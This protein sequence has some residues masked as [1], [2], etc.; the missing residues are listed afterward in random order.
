MCL[1]VSWHSSLLFWVSLTLVGIH[2]N[3]E[4]VGMKSDVLGVWGE[5]NIIQ[6]RKEMTIFGGQVEGVTASLY[7]KL[8]G[9][10][11]RASLFQLLY[12]SASRCVLSVRRATCSSP[13]ILKL[14]DGSQMQFLWLS[15]AAEVLWQLS[16][17]DTWTRTGEFYFLGCQEGC[18]GCHGSWHPDFYCVKPFITTAYH[19][20]CFLT[21]FC[22]VSCLLL[23]LGNVFFLYV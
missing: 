21:M 22:Q 13:V 5:A 9:W 4:S 18:I 11:S 10:K 2:P 16:R 8:S 7:S 20:T 23:F 12:L 15:G 3:C 14:W 1:Y 17:P 19:H 6:E